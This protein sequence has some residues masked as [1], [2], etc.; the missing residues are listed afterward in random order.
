MKEPKNVTNKRVQER[1]IKGIYDILTY[2]AKE[3]NENKED[4][5]TK[6]LDSNLEFKATDLSLSLSLDGE[7][8]NVFEYAQEDT[9]LIDFKVN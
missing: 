6:L 4:Y 7:L 3:I 1:N 9:V 5:K 8:I 2:C